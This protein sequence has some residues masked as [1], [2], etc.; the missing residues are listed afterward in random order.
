LERAPDEIGALGDGV[1]LASRVLLVKRKA[2]CL[3]VSRHADHVANEGESGAFAVVTMY[4]A[5][6]IQAP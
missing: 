1:C 2:R 3:L 6:R 4:K 5:A